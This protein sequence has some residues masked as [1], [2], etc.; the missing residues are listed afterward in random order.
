LNTIKKFI[1]QYDNQNKDKPL[2]KNAALI[3]SFFR[4][5]HKKTLGLVV[6]FFAT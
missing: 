2:F 5:K 3:V 1:K 6:G 4:N